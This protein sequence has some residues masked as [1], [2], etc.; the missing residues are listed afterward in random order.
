MS[1][2]RAVLEQTKKEVDESIKLLDEADD[3]DFNE[4]LQTRIKKLM[5]QKDR[6]FS[7]LLAC[8]VKPECVDL[9][10]LLLESADKEMD[11]ILTKLQ[12]Q[13]DRDEEEETDEKED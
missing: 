5:E 13:V 1:G 4:V 6:D 3:R 11:T 7:V 10:R 9:F 8:D 2:H 12:T